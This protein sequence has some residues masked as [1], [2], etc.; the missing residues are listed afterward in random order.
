MHWYCIRYRVLP[1]NRGLCQC[2]LKDVLLSLT[3][4]NGNRFWKFFRRSTFV[5]KFSLNMPLFHHTFH[6]LLHH[7]AKYLTHFLTH[8]GK[9]AG[10]FAPCCITIWT[11]RSRLFVWGENLCLAAT[12]RGG[13]WQ[14][15]SITSA[16]LKDSARK[17]DRISVS[18]QLPHVQPKSS[19]ADAYSDLH[20]NAKFANPF[21]FLPRDAY[22]YSADIKL[23]RRVCLPVCHTVTWASE[24]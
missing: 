11:Q 18:E 6:A 14:Q 13:V 2:E 22:M 24:L 4:P 3:L 9:L 17:K 10:F 5:I 20:S 1:K 15:K 7:L 16:A 19:F 8:I 23:P 12:T 21:L